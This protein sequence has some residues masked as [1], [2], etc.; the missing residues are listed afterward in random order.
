MAKHHYECTITVPS[1][2][3]TFMQPNSIIANAAA[4]L[5]YGDQTDTFGDF[6][7][8]DHANV[9]GNADTSD[10]QQVYMRFSIDADENS[11]AFE[12]Q[13]EQLA[14]IERFARADPTNLMRP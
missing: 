8:V 1:D 2:D 6:G 3:R 5:A 7:V 11:E 10:A 14:H 12:E 9:L 13:L 4:Y